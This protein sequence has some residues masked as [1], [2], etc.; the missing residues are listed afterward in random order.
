M[1]FALEHS[2][3]ASFVRLVKDDNFD[4]IVR[5]V[6]YLNHIVMALFY[7]KSHSIHNNI[8]IVTD[9]FTKD[10]HMAKFA[11]FVL[12]YTNGSCT[13]VAIILNEFFGKG[14]LSRTCWPN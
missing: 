2:L 3:Q 7:A 9:G 4:L 5:I 1:S 11:L 12:A 8:F 14:C 13:M 10:F 6:C